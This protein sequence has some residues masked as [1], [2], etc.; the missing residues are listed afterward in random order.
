MNLATVTILGNLTADPKLFPA[1]NGKKAFVRFSVAV[2]EKRGEEESVSYY[3]VSA[4]GDLAE[5]ITTS[6]SKGHRVIVIGR[7]G[8]YSEP[9]TL[10][11][12]REVQR[13]RIQLIA[14]AVGPDLFHQFARV[15]KVASNNTANAQSNGN[16]A[17][18]AAQSAA[19]QPAVAPASAPVA[20][21]IPADE[22]P[23]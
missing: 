15:G 23:F 6:L 12:G 8:T 14:S 10:D 18:A 20:Q 13:T 2:N 7:L 4:F 11:D 21:P 16:G 3:D 9:V 19:A 17:Q 5:G 1:S 22:E